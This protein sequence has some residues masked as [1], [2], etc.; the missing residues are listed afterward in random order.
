MNNTLFN[1]T[2]WGVRGS[3][4]TPTLSNQKYGGNTSCI[5]IQIGER[6]II[7]DA[8]TG[9][10]ELGN[11]LLSR[12]REVKADIFISHA[13][14]DHIQGFPFFGPA[15]VEGNSFT[16]YGE[17]KNQQAFSNIIKN[18]MTHPY[19]P[20]E[21]DKM[22]ANFSFIEV[23]G[24]QSLD[25]GN[26]I[27]ISTLNLNHPGGCIGYR[28]DFKGKSCCYITDTEYTGSDQLL[29]SFIQGSDVLILDTQFTD[30]EYKDRI[31][32]GHSTWQTGAHLSREMNV[33]KL[34]L[35]HHDINH[36]DVK[37]AYIE[38]QAQ[39]IHKDTIAAREGLTIEL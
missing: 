25:L 23:E 9:I 12:N 38:E 8:G 17:A 13:H 3:C 6:C 24:N 18:S 31:G 22:K 34:L 32:W 2:F 7:F 5:Q 37:I 27:L 26:N 19:F 10:I 4:P 30:E 35:F 28:I 39:K 33:K 36:S 11:A 29:Q 21:W 16:L 1:I 14:W 20:M 15:F